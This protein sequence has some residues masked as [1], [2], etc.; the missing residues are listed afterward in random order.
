MAFNDHKALFIYNDSVDLYL[1]IKAS[2][3][4]YFIF[5]I[6]VDSDSVVSIYKHITFDS[7]YEYSRCY[8]IDGTLY[9]TG[10]NEIVLESFR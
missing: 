6:D 5:K 4:D 9:I 3:K 1:G 10:Y 7:S 8:L 2:S